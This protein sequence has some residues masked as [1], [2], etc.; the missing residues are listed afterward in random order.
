MI[1][2]GSDHTIR[3]LRLENLAPHSNRRS[4]VGMLSPLFFSRTF[5]CTKSD[6]LSAL[7]LLLPRSLCLSTSYPPARSDLG[8][9]TCSACL[10]L[11]GPGA[12]WAA[13]TISRLWVK[14]NI[15]FEAPT[16]ARSCLPSYSK[17]LLIWGCLLYT[18]PSPRDLST[19]RMP[20]SA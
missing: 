20:S 3:L 15:V 18:S 2:E 4:I 1:T 19:S 6:R 8:G 11:G 12:S 17:T 5:Q 9:T 14:L 13:K 10:G 16:K 7:S